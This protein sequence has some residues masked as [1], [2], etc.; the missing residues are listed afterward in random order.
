MKTKCFAASLDQV[1]GHEPGTR[2]DGIDARPH[3]IP[4]PQGKHS[5][6]VGGKEA[7][8]YRARSKPDY[9]RAA[10]IFGAVES[11]GRASLV[12]FSLGERAG[13]RA[14]QPLIV[15]TALLL[16]TL[17]TV[18]TTSA[19]EPTKAQLD[20]FENKIRPIFAENCSKCHSP[21]KGKIKGELELDWKGGWEKGGE[22]GPAIVP[23]D[24]EKS[25]LIKA[26]RYT[27]PDLQ[28]PPKGEKLSETQVNDLVAWV[29]MGAPDPRTARPAAAPATAQYDG[30]KGKDHWA[31]K[32]VKKP[33]PPA[34]KNQTWV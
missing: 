23:G 16:L 14:S 17:S 27:D 19:A 3:P 30:D 11:S 8:G 18:S 26:V 6:L 12:S 21:A 1:V 13:V 24:P 29:K 9:T 33:S 7:S 31:F 10:S 5:A 34:V 20:F 15:F 2:R 32:P 25:L 28:M 4:L 22:K